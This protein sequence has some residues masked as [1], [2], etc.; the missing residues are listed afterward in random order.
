LA[1]YAYLMATGNPRFPQ[2]DSANIDALAKLGRLSRQQGDLDAALRHLRQA[3]SLD[4]R[5][6]G[7]QCEVA[8]VLRGLS[9]FNEARATYLA[10]LQADPAHIN[11]L[12][13]LGRMSRQ[14]GDLEAALGYLQ[15]AASLDPSRLGLQC[16]MAQVLRGLSRISEARA[17]Y[18]AVLQA[19]PSQVNALA[20]LGRMSRQQGGLDAAL[21]YLQQA[22]S[23]D[24][25][26]SGLQCEVA[27]VLRELGR[28]DEA[29]ATYLAVLQADPI[30]INALADLGRMSRQQGDLEAALGY[31]QQAAS[32]DPS[33]LWLQ[34]EAAQVLRGLSR[35]GDAR[36]T[37]RAVLQ[38]DPSDASALLGLG[39]IERQLGDHEASLEFLE[40]ARARHADRIGL[41]VEVA[42]TLRLLDRLDEAEEICRSAAK[43][44][45][46]ANA[47]LRGL[48][49]IFVARGQM[50][51]AIT[52]AR[53]ACIV[54]PHDVDTRMNLSAL[55]RDTG[56]ITEASALIE[57]TLVDNPK[58]PGVWFE[59]GL[60]LR[61]RSERTAALAAFERA[62]ELNHERG[63]MEAAV[64]HLA[65]GQ[66]EE[67]RDAYRRVL[68]VAPAHFDAMLGM[69]D[70]QMLAGDYDACMATCDTL[71][72]AYPKR[73]APYRLKCLALI[74]LERVEEA[75]RI[76]SETATGGPALAQGDALRL[77]VYRLCGLRDQAQT[78][79]SE[80]RVSTTR[81][82]P[83]WMQSVLTRLAFYDLGGAKRAIE[84]PPAHW[85]SE[86]A[87]AAHAE[88]MLAD[89]QWRVRDSI[90]LF[91]R[92]LKINR[93]DADAHHNLA[94]LYLLRAD[95]DHVSLHLRAMIEKSE[96]KRSLRGQSKNTSQNMIGQLLNELRLD[97]PLSTR[98]ARI[99]DGE[100]LNQVDSLR[101]IVEGQPGLTPPAMYLML[102]LRQ[103]GVFD[104]PPAGTPRGPSGD[105][106]PRKIMQYWDQTALPDGVAALFRT[107]IQRHPDFEHRRFDHS[108]ARAYLSSHYPDEVLNAYRRAR[109]PAQASD[110]FRLA[111]LLREG[112]FYVDAD[113]RCVG[114]L[115][116]VAS[117]GA[118]F[119]GYQEMFA[120]LANNFLACVPGE[121]VIE[122]ALALAVEALNRGDNDTIWLATGPGLLTR[123]FAEVFARQGPAWREWLRTRR[124]LDRKDLVHVSWCHA[125]LSYKNT[126]K[127][128]LHSAFKARTAQR[129]RG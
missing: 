31:L 54:A 41:Q 92:A 114:H 48:S 100:P 1:G 64:E 52:Y 27:Q 86:R 73:L 32:L 67:A 13:D 129:T 40:T 7:L 12:A 65:L 81:Y 63:W 74:Q 110:L 112:G 126:S 6:L 2:A 101:S 62:A 125:I 35:I 23:L 89:Q 102:A 16:E 115:S 8:Q 55:Y 15:Q 49:Q 47:P 128:W 45:P 78:L 123:A 70:L 68:A 98:L 119:I 108:T 97:I 46:R 94:R 87:R 105:P 33:R 56:R 21:R 121:P 5:R 42:A 103:S 22:V 107:W 28:F 58:H 61:C 14:Q 127:S 36:A 113:D 37:Y 93:H 44:D 20:D 59:R 80:P 91:E 11:A 96:S 50:A 3:A 30:H 25:S 84:N 72:A 19:D 122:R 18:L 24:P 29:R 79:L 120:T 82:F 109:H 10:V 4:P 99:L 76:V 43:A 117:D 66:A 26:R 9:R 69:A 51:A 39:M 106:I 124:I 75:S 116:S 83:L 88:A 57:E 53:A 95:V 104:K 118:E 111:Y 34:C 60:L 85:Q 71:I 77:E 38:A 90:A 17:T